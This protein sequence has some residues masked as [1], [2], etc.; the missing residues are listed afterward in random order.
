M[1]VK[2]LKL[3]N[4]RNYT[5][6]NLEFDEKLNIIYGNNAQ[7]KT[8]ILEAIYMFSLGK[9]NRSAKDTDLIKFGEETSQIDMDFISKTRL[10]SGSI[11]I[12][13]GKRKK[14]SINDI[15]IRKNSE[16]VGNLNVVF[17][18]PEYL[19]LIR[20]GPKMR[21][22]NLDVMICQLK[23]AYLTAVS[24]YKRLNEQKSRLLKNE[25]IDTTLL[26]VLN[27]KILDL[28]VY[29][30]TVRFD[31]IKKVEKIAQ[32]IQLEVSGGN[33]NLTMNYI[34]SG[35]RITEDNVGNLSVLSA[36][37]MLKLREREIKYRECIFGPHRDD[38]EFCINDNDLKYFG[39]QGQQKTSILVQKIA[40]V[41]LM[42]EEKG[43]Y[44]ILLLDDIMSELDTLRQDFILNKINKGQI[45]ITCTDSEKFKN[46]K[47]G[48]FIRIDKGEMTECTS[49]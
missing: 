40:E 22:K 42:R 28:A 46:V 5:S 36:E 20:E 24:D 11:K 44:P 27:E 23:P 25:R 17:F 35:I 33:E 21:R 43:E 3:S 13:K 15:P 2:N 39:S 26:D 16:L 18:G 47:S 7:G 30:S 12:E 41:E 14:I 45:F 1:I 8:N 48:R 9:S 38:I 32:Q 4:F 49:I 6:D 10:C 34:T 31:Y 37:S 29:I 19:S